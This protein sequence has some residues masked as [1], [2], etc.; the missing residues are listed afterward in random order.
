[1]QA[2]EA[3][4]IHAKVEF[5]VVPK[6]GQSDSDN[7]V[8]AVSAARLNASSTSTQI[9]TALDSHSA[10]SIYTSPVAGTP[11]SAE[12]NE[13][14]KR[15]G[16]IRHGNACISEVARRPR[17]HR[18]ERNFD[19]LG[20][21]PPKAVS[22]EEDKQTG[23]GDLVSSTQGNGTQQRRRS[24]H[25]PIKPTTSTDSQTKEDPLFAAL[26][27]PDAEGYG[28]FRDYKN[29]EDEKPSPWRRPIRSPDVANIDPT[30][31]ALRPSAEITPT[32]PM[33][34]GVALTLEPSNRSEVGI[35]AEKIKSD[36]SRQAGGQLLGGVRREDRHH[37]MA[38][39]RNALAAARRD[40]EDDDNAIEDDDDDDE[41]VEEYVGKGKGVIRVNE[42][43]GKPGDKPKEVPKDEP[44]NQPKD[45]DMEEN[46]SKRKDTH[47][48]EPM[49]ASKRKAEGSQQ[50]VTQ[51]SQP[52]TGN[53]PR[54]HGTLSRPVEIPARLLRADYPP[55]WMAR[56]LREAQEDTIG[57]RDPGGQHTRTVRFDPIPA[58][59]VARPVP[60][61][62]GGRRTSQPRG[63]L[64]V[65]RGTTA[66]D[67]DV[68]APW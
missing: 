20:L 18:M 39:V 30:Y 33:A 63:I 58:G 2:R 6:A 28:K 21:N 17:Y 37:S 4:A 43:K 41:V 12:Q 68:A 25:G 55:K 61:F 27:W 48:D 47:K 52:T 34:D 19:P 38:A 54:Q 67:E 60:G 42:V 10:S 13:Q 15:S 9:S 14:I 35:L 49:D 56:M 51:L 36:P 57:D 11:S 65:A 50:R 1:M 40:M 8:Q 24:E 46:E 44:K 5:P 64:R 22:E 32:R 3:A 31:G 16:M 62:G 59:P 29:A 53:K 26:T 23:Q 66:G 45:K 7:R